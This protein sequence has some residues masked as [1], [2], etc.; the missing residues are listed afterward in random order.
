MLVYRGKLVS[1]PA[2]LPR[3]IL[4]DLIHEKVFLGPV[5]VNDGTVGRL[6]E[7]PSGGLRIEYWKRGAGWIEA[8][9]SLTLSSFMPG[10]MRPVSADL[11][12]RV[13]MPPLYNTNTGAKLVGLFK[14][15][16]WDLACR[17]MPPGHA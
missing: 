10:K 2:A 13:G 16:A 8:P 1:G 12:A 9:K 7:L 14:E 4:R 15:R 11:A 17:R 5:N 6:V 3:L